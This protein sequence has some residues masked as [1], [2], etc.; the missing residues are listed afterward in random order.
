MVAYEANLLL[1]LL[2]L[3]ILPLTTIL[4]FETSFKRISTGDVPHYTY[5]LRETMALA[6]SLVSTSAFTF[7]S[8]VLSILF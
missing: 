3:P 5:T 6:T 8:H 4:D 2:F 1:Q 7:K